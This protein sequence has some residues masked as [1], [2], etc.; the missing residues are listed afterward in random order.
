MEAT[1]HAAID[2]LD[3]ERLRTRRTMK[4]SRYPNDVL[5]AWVAEMDYP[6][7]TAVHGAVRDVL[8]RDDLGYPEPDGLAE[9]FAG[10]AQRAQRWTPDPALAVPVADVMAGVEAA[11]RV[12]TV[13][14]D[15]VVIATPAYP[16]F[17]ALL[18]DLHRRAVSWPLADTDDGWQLDLDGLDAALAVGA[19]AVLLCSPHNPVGRVWSAD[20]L[21]AVAHVAERHGVPVV[22]DEVHAPLLATGAR[23]TPFATVSDN[24]VT[25]TSISKGWNVP[26]LKCALLVAQPS[27]AHVAAAVPERERLRP[28]VPGVVA[29][30]AAW[31]DDGG[32]LDAVRSYLDRTRAELAAWA[33]HHARVRTHPGEAGYLAW[34]DLRATGLGDD[35][36]A[37]LLD[38]ARVALNPGHTFTRPAAEGRGCVRLNHGT[39]L[40]LLREVF[41]RIDSVLEKSA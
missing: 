26:G 9:A 18:D 6:L 3:T 41:D 24:T 12:L 8:Q 22:S 23:F 28:S 13:P 17:F 37:V 14:G 20:E 35:P 19:R 5:P 21:R 2:A 34:L 40:P 38:R 27:T 1:L 36:A 25:V 29:S 32:W 33:H 39:S 31:T 11:L 10:W 4:W 30:I 16:P 15:G 7:A